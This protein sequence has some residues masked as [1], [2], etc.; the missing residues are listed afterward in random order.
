M[1]NQQFNVVFYSDFTGGLNN[2]SSRQDLQLNETPDCLDVSFNARGGFASRRGVR[3]TTTQASLSGG[4]IG[5]QFSAGTEVLWGIDNAG[6][7]WT[8]TAGGTFTSVVTAL[9]ADMTRVVTGSVWGDKLYFVNWLNAG[10]LLM[11]YWNGTAFTTLGNVVNN[12]YSAPTGGN[13]P[14]ARLSATHQGHMFWA[15]TVESSVRYRSRV[16][17]S[18]PLQPEDF[19]AADYFDINPDDQ[20]DQVTALVPFKDFLLVF[21]R[22]GVFAI[23]GYDRD[24]FV[25]QRV[26][27]GAGAASAGCVTVNAGVCYWWSLD[28]NVYAFNG[29]GVVPI[30]DRISNVVVDGSVAQN[31][32]L[33]RVAWVDN[34]LFV[35]LVLNAGGRVLFM[36]DPQVGK[37]GA[38]TKWSFAPTS[39]FWWRST[40]T[41]NGLYMTLES[42][43]GLFDMAS[44]VQEQDSIL[45][46]TSPIA[47]YYKTAWFTDKDAGLRKKWR[48]PHITVACGDPATL[49]I[50]VYHDFMESTTVKQHQIALTTSGVGN[51]VWGT[52]LWDTATWQGSDPSYEF[53]RTPSLGKSHAVQLKFFVTDHATKWWID[54]VTLPYYIKTYR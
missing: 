49:N 25:V 48:R 23:Y 4:Y 45:G 30:G 16:R 20:T 36:Y 21:K 3:T 38:W 12:N 13:A 1:A 37:A 47:A 42:K 14:L 27:V 24:S 8:Y 51:M 41:V 43:G 7:L 32:D 31:S 52:G 44:S 54:S 9:P 29:R 10:S 53:D 40:G 19:A 35:S 28:G 5:G 39:M 50:H 11:R 26:S 6:A 46:V 34:Q 22:K 33:N 15:D 2:R 18:H 17:W